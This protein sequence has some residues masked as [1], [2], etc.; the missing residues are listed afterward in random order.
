MWE[1]LPQAE[2]ERRIALLEVSAA[3]GDLSA[4]DSESFG[5]KAILGLW[6]LEAGDTDR[7]ME[8]WTDFFGTENEVANE[9]IDPR[10]PA[11]VLIEAAD[12]PDNWPDLGTNISTPPHILSM[13]WEQ[14]GPSPELAEHPLLPMECLGDIVDQEPEVILGAARNSGLDETTFEELMG[15]EDPDPWRPWSELRIELHRSVALPA[16]RLADAQPLDSEWRESFSGPGDSVFR[17]EDVA[18]AVA[19]VKHPGLPVDRL[20]AYASDIN[21]AVRQAVAQNPR[22][23]K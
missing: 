11:S 5:E 18:I 6:A 10:T 8:L 7:A 1:H 2:R 15:L 12:D 3:T 14:G 21:P 4:S 20:I 13:I 16:S 9:L 17:D 23:P 22:T 19:L